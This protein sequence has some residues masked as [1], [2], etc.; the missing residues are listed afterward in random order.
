VHVPLAGSRPGNRCQDVLPYH[1]MAMKRNER[2]A[3][4]WGSKL[5]VWIHVKLCMY[6]MY[7][8]WVACFANAIRTSRTPTGASELPPPPCH[9]TCGGM[10]GPRAWNHMS[11]DSTAKQVCSCFSGKGHCQSGNGRKRDIHETCWCRG[12]LVT[13]L[14]FPTPGRQPVPSGPG[15]GNLA[16]RWTGVGGITSAEPQI[17]L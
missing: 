16:S 7:T 4:N 11:T 2:N 10:R 3:S 6:I 12:C 14:G 17:W 8:V 9:L 5:R 1:H 13:E 15:L